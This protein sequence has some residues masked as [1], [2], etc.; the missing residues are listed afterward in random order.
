MRIVWRI[1]LGLLL[2]LGLGEGIMRVY[3]DLLP[4]RRA[5]YVSDPQAGYRLR[6]QSAW[7][8]STDYHVNSLGFRD[9]EHAVPKPAGTWR[10]VGIGDSF[11]FGEVR[12]RDNFLRIA[13]SMINAHP[14]GITHPRTSP[15]AA[16]ADSAQTSPEPGLAAGL[17]GVSIPQIG[18]NPRFN[19]KTMPQV[20]M[21]LMGLGG[22]SPENYLGVLRSCALGVQPDL[23]LLCFFVGNDVTGIP[24][25][26]KVLHGELY[27]VSSANPVLNLLRKSRLFEYAERF[28]YFKLRAARLRS[29]RSPEP[30]PSGAEPSPASNRGLLVR[31]YDVVEG[32]RLP[33]FLRLPSTQMEDLWRQ[34][35]DYLSGLHRS[36]RAAGVPWALIIIPDEI[37]VDPQ[38]R[39]DVLRRLGRSEDEYDFSEPDRRLKDF[40]SQH[41]VPMLDLLPILRAAHRPDDRLYLPND[42]HWSVRGNQVA[43]EAVA[44]FVQ[45]LMRTAL[46]AKDKARGHRRPA[47]P[48][49]NVKTGEGEQESGL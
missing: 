1:L 22:Y 32:D 36:C 19:P 3:L 12:L 5:S 20:D 11:V 31:F 26:S 24:T 40:A 14:E 42:T 34:A 17:P 41:S 46:L 35:E 6:P 23:V 33:V 21:V 47:P 38:V 25:R 13:E 15:A 27:S 16:A 10:V 49:V 37:Q 43:G 8:D 44:V 9:R 2:G 28:V 7:E 29:I 39:S 45:D 18:S 48:R 4:A 30:G